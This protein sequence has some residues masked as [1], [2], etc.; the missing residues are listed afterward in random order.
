MGLLTGKPPQAARSDLQGEA[1]AGGERG[2]PLAFYNGFGLFDRW[3]AGIRGAPG[4]TRW[5]AT[6]EGRLG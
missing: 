5:Q 3:P 1:G 6:S 2:A 4:G